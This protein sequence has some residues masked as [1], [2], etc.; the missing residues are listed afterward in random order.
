[1]SPAPSRTFAVV[2]N[3]AAGNRR[4]GRQ[5]ERLQRALDAAG[6]PYELL[7]TVRPQHAAELARRAAAAFDV[8]VAAGG[9]GTLQEV[10]T[11]LF[12][13]EERATLGVLPLGTGNDFAELLGIPKQPEAALR[14]LL[15]A[16]PVPVDGGVV[17]WRTARTGGLWNEAVFVNA[18]G[19]GFDAEVAFRAQRKK[20]LRGKLA[21]AAAIG[22][23]LRSWP[24]PEVEVR[25]VGEAV[26]VTPSGATAPL[27]DGSG[28]VYRG[29]LF[30][31]CAA[32]GRSVGGGF[33][34]T[35]HAEVDDGRLDLCCVGA[36]PLKRILMLLPKVFRGAHLGA[37]EVIS[38]RLGGVTL[39]A[40]SGLPIHLDGEIVTR[41]AVEVEVAVQPAAFRVL[42]P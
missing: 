7:P 10:A 11:G 16:E 18:V 37:P 32:N 3:P 39:T 34:L 5:R 28:P 6:V 23:V 22:G 38:E 26:A 31:C 4:A 12:G 29:P 42:R 1:M 27:D 21:Y 15:R 41:E 19:I 20:R 35:P 17:R 33:R 13:Q 30:L 14:A 9:D 2:L 8:V 24:T 25:R 40:S 36:L